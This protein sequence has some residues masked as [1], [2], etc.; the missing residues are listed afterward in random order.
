MGILVKR[1]LFKHKN[2]YV[3]NRNTIM[4]AYLLRGFHLIWTDF[5]NCNILCRLC[6][7]YIDFFIFIKHFCTDVFFLQ[8]FDIYLKLGECFFK[9]LPKLVKFTLE[10]QKFLNFV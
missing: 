7:M 8:C 2:D 1:I 10:K 3:A 5:S 4:N 6:I 9:K